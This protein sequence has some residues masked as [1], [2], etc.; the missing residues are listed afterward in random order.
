MSRTAQ[1]FDQSAYQVRLEW[2]VEGLRRLAP[3]DVVV[4]VDVLRYS[5][6]VIAAVE[7]GTDA[8]LAALREGSVNGAAVVDACD[9]SSLVIAGAL[10]NA[11]AVA[12]AILREQERRGKR[13]SIAVVAAGE[14]VLD[15]QDAGTLRFA[16]EDLLGAGAIVA[17]LGDLGVDHCS[18]DAAAA[19]E[20]F[21]PLRRAVRHLLS[22][23]GSGREL[24]ERGRSDEV[25]AAASLDSSTVVPVRVGDR[26][27]RQ[28]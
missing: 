26:F 25:A 5:T 11:G 10:V 18:P 8:T 16:V 6:R 19:G 12:T 2:G 24:A 7:Q 28:T 13:T 9:P 1:S 27:A 20:A 15:G 4:V 3:S 23:S 22:A 17:A 21:R 14:I